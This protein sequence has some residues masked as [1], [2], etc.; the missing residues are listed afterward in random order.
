MMRDILHWTPRVLA[1]AFALFLA[2][3]ALDIFSEK[4]TIGKTVIALLMHLIP[5]F[6]L[7]LVVA[8]AWRW[9]LV[10]GILFVLLGTASIFVFHTYREPISFMVISLPI[11][12]V[13]VLFIWDAFN[14]MQLPQ[15]SR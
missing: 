8:I 15:R 11:F 3:F 14:T 7:L 2:L 1:I 4:L 12:V 5:T 10:G 9:R 6:L 13:G